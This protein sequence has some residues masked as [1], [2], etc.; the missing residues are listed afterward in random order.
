MIIETH[1]RLSILLVA[2]NKKTTLYFYII[3]ISTL[4]WGIQCIILLH[5]SQTQKYVYIYIV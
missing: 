5:G 3:K 1:V 4:A 2:E